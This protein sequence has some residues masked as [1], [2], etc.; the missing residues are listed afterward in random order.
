MNQSLNLDHFSPSP[1]VRLW[2]VRVR[3]IA[4]LLETQ[5]NESNQQM[6]SKFGILPNKGSV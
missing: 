3:S 2:S 1:E 5:L 6:P 4:A